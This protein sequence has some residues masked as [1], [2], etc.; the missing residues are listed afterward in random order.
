LAG[1]EN[2]SLT[3]GQS[4]LHQGIPDPPGI[5]LGYNWGAWG[6]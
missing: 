5:L 1:R 2:L 6:L 4:P 3:S